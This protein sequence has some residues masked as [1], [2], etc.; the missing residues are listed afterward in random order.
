MTGVLDQLS[1]RLLR[2]SGD[3]GLDESRASAI[4][5]DVI[6]AAPK[7]SAQIQ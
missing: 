1:A 4:K 2:D 3:A 5:A 6:W 7:I